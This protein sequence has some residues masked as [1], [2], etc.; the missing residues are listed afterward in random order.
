MTQEK[1][2]NIILPI[3]DIKYNVLNEINSGGVEMRP[4]FQFTLQIF[5][6]IITTFLILIVSIFLLNF[7][8]FITRINHHASLLAFGPR[9]IISFIYFFPWLLLLIDIVL[10]FLLEHFVRKFRFGY[11]F[12]VLYVISALLGIT[13]IFGS[14]LDRMTSFNDKV[15]ESREHLPDPIGKFY[16]QAS[17]QLSVGSGVCYCKILTISSNGFLLEDSRAGGTNPIIVAIPE[18]SGDLEL[19][20][21]LQVGDMVLVAGTEKDGVIE[22]FGIRK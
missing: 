19:L 8:S 14:L 4:K 17:K 15:L 1:E 20:S 10:I 16:D 21:T 3:R 5:L 7:I 2:Q 13:V 6:L 18:D 11:R 9:G 22:A 12:P